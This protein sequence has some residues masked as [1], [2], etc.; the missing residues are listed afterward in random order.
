MGPTLV[1]LRL[2]QNRAQRETA[3]ALSRAQMPCSQGVV[4][5]A[6]VKNRRS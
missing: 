1:A 6:S 4:L 5:N 3:A 2:Y